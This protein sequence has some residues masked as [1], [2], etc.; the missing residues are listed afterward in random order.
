MVNGEASKIIEKSNSGLV[1]SGD[2]ENLVSNIKKIS[3]MSYNELNT[4]GD[5]SLKCYQE[6]FDREVLFKK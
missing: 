6:N 2:Y 1:N 5:N 4:M 3:K